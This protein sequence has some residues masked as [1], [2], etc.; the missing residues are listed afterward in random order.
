MPDIGFE[1]D[2]GPSERNESELMVAPKPLACAT[3]AGIPVA[4]ARLRPRTR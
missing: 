3:S 4:A 1:L 2:L